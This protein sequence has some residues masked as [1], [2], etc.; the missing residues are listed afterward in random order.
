MEKDKTLL[1]KPI[2]GAVMTILI[3]SYIVS[4]VL[5]AN[6][7]Q[8]KTESANIMTVSDSISSKGYFIRDE[9]LISSKDE[10]YISYVF[11]DGDK[12]S[13][14]EAVAN[15]YS[16]SESATVKQQ[17]NRLQSQIDKLKVLDKTGSAIS[18]TPDELDKTISGD[19]SKMNQLV[20]D[21]DFKSTGN[22]LDSLLY[23]LNER[24]IVTGKTNGFES[25]INELEAELEELKKTPAA[26]A[27]GKAVRSPS[28]GYFVCQADGYEDICKTDE[29]N[30]IMP[31]D[32]SSRLEKKKEVSSDII[33]KTIEGVYWYVACE[34]N[35]EEALKIKTSE[36]LSIELPLVNNE[37]I[38]VELESINQKSMTTDAVVILRGSFMNKEMAQVRYED[39]SVVVETY[40][41]IYIPKKAVHECNVDFEIK[42]ESGNKKTVTKTVPG[43]YIKIGNEIL[44]K[45]IFPVYMG[46]DFVI[47]KKAPDDDD[48]VSNDTGPL[49]P[50]DNVVVEGANLYDGKIIDRTNQK[51]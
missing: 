21:R 35:A 38:S 42:D 11:D 8:I 16:N 19:L 14:N 10:G 23:S 40:T 17:M 4:V 3:L 25:K 36:N 33:G 22:T 43:V 31:G 41:G 7:V 37:L 44:V 1:V 27:N 34:V 45:Q 39:I 5:K 48:A 49:K 6:F 51:T 46:D 50:Y 30:S 18:T 12:V 13:K 28:T 24:Q 2:V 9:H 47:C 15:V 20:D 32:L 29:I 26:S